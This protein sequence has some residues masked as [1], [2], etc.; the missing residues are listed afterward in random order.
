MD[1]IL[2]TPFSVVS[3]NEDGLQPGFVLTSPIRPVQVARRFEAQVGELIKMLE[4]NQRREPKTDCDFPRKQLFWIQ[5]YT[6]SR[7]NFSECKA[8]HNGFQSQNIMAAGFACIM[9]LVSISF[10]A[11]GC[12]RY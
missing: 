10:V 6:T 3:V 12:F 1:T 9:H 4:D 11:S 2:L 8:D 7:W 5:R